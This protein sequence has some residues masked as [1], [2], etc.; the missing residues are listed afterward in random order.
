V[1]KG[2]N[3]ITGEIVAVKVVEKKKLKNKLE[4][5]LLENEIQVLKKM[6]NPNVLKLKDVY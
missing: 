6:D 2:I 3:E 1:Y 4:W 5:Q